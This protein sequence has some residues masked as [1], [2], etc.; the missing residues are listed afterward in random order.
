MKNKTE[1]KIYKSEIHE[2]VAKRREIEKLK[3]DIKRIEEDNNFDLRNVRNTVFMLAEKENI[4]LDTLNNKLNFPNG[5]IETF[6]HQGHIKRKYYYELLDYFDITL[7]E[8][9][10]KFYTY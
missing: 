10:L 6:C 1:N 9:E 2:A 5:T 7:L 4:S 8:E 3:K